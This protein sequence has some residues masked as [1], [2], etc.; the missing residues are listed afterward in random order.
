L[1]EDNLCMYCHRNEATH[2]INVSRNNSGASQNVCDG[3]LAKASYQLKN[4]SH[5]DCKFLCK[6]IKPKIWSVS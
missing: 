6:R 1:D 4:K 5:P 2:R 3:C